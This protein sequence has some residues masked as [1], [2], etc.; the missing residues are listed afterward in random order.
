MEEKVERALTMKRY[1]RV[2]AKSGATW[3]A[4]GCRGE[5]RG[6]RHVCMFFYQTLLHNVVRTE[7]SIPLVATSGMS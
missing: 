6:S 5:A 3:L 7:K 4:V 2:A 1:R